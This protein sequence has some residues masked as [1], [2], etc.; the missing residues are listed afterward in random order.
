MWTLAHTSNSLSC[1][2]VDSGSK[3][4]TGFRE[5]C[6]KN[7]KVRKNSCGDWNLL[8]GFEWPFILSQE[9]LFA[10]AFKIV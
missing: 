6:F 2:K 7:L 8:S 5:T 3:D 9:G 10:I 4:G 1:V